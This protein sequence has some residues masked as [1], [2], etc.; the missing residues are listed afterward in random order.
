MTMKMSKFLS[1]L[2]INAD[3]SSPSQLILAVVLILYIIFDVPTPS[4][5][6]KPVDNLYGQIIIALVAIVLFTQTNPILG[7][8]GVLGA[9]LLI[10]RNHQ[11]SGRYGL[12][13]YVPSESNKNAEFARLNRNFTSTLEE[14]MVTKMVPFVTYDAPASVNYQPILEKQH[15]ASPIHE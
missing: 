1:T 2:K 7:I 11:A 9:Y 6:A 8:L 13:H 14:E 4:S 15:D 5:I 10:K 3:S 12:R